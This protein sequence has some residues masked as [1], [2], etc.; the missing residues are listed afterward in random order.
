MG[1]GFIPSAGDP[2][3]KPGVGGFPLRVVR[4]EQERL[5]APD[6]STGL[7]CE[8]PRPTPAG[9]S[10]VASAEGRLRWAAL[11]VGQ[12]TG[13]AGEGWPHAGRG[14]LWYAIFEDREVPSLETL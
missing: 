10:P 1:E 3:R 2:C 8:P 13:G 14:T 12:V 6:R 4:E 5:Q 7:L 9:T 11:Q